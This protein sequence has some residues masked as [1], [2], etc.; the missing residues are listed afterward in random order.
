MDATL[1]ILT[2]RTAFLN[3]QAGL[4]E[5]E[6][7]LFNHYNKSGKDVLVLDNLFQAPDK[8]SLVVKCDNLVLSTTG[9]YAEKLAP[10]MEAFEKMNYAPK[11][12]VF[13][14]ENTALFFCGLARELKKKYGTK[15]YFPDVL[16]RNMLMEVAWI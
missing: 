1:D 3:G 8:L 15:F 13:M 16:D 6:E 11:V 5:Q 2:G 14:G 4:H 9:M 12:V 10:L 7:K